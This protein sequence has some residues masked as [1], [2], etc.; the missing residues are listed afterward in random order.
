M[1]GK[2][3]ISIYIGQSDVGSAYGATA[4]LVIL[5][6]CTYYSS[7]ILYF[8]AE[9]TMAYSSPYGHE[10]HPFHYAVTPK[11]V[12]AEQVT[13]SIQTDASASIDLLYYQSK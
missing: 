8:G 9:F 6:L 5:I 4:F 3:G 13:I 2:F 10:I 11:E 12:E 7:I 1:L